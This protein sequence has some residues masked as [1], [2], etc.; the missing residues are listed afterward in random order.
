MGIDLRISPGGGSPGA[1]DWARNVKSQDPAAGSALPSP[2]PI[3]Y[4]I[5]VLLYPI[6]PDPWMIASL[7]EAFII[8]VG[9]LMIRKWRPIPPV[10]PTPPG[11]SK[12]D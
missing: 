10:P 11:P 5:S 12:R 3:G 4:F 1:T 7:I 9:F 2:I 8:L 6:G